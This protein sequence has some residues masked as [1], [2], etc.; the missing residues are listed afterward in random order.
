MNAIRAC[1]FIAGCNLFE[2]KDN[3]KKA[4][5]Q[6]Y[7]PR[8]I[9]ITKLNFTDSFY[10]LI[11]V[12]SGYLQETVSN[13]KKKISETIFKSHHFQ[14]MVSPIFTNNQDIVMH[15][16]LPSNV[17]AVKSGICVPRDMRKLNY[18]LKHLIFLLCWR[19]CAPGGRV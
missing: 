12:Y 6:K 10:T 17:C 7:P 19:A 1:S 3:Y 5:L 18:P 2:C 8:S 15:T 4:R 13:I 11:N 14:T 9:L 16:V